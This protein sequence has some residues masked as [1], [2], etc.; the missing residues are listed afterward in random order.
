MAEP[1]Y[2]FVG[3][4]AGRWKIIRM[5]E[6]IGMP[7][8]SAA[9]VDIL[10]KNLPTLPQN[11][12][13]VLRGVTSYERYVNKEEQALLAA[14]QPTLGRPEATC[15]A[16]IPIKKSAAWWSLPQAERRAIMEA[17]SHHIR[18]GLQYLPAIARRLHHC[19]GIDESF[20]FLTW[21]EYAPEDAEAF[22]TLTRT[23][24]STEEW[25]YVEREIDIRLT[26]A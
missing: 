5:N 20:D 6:V 4:K 18:T 25:M 7:L 22:E 10:D 15:A 2:S 3:G 16:L 19:D 14:A 23:L 12:A 11:A 8:A 17:R 13:W 21:F 26:R 24:R 9:Y 1:P